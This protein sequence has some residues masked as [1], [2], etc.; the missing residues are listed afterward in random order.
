MANWSNRQQNGSAKTL[1]KGSP[2][3]VGMGLLPL[4]ASDIQITGTVYSN[5]SESSM[6]TFQ[7]R[8]EAG[9]G[10]LYDEDG[11]TYDEA[12]HPIYDDE[13]FYDNAGAPTTWSNRSES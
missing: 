5:R 3:G 13:L 4:Y 8:I 6:G 9:G 10:W 12:S 2:L 1:E 11:I 7:Q